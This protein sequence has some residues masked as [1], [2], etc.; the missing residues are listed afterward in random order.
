MNNPFTAI[1]NYFKKKKENAKPTLVKQKNGWDT[2]SWNPKSGEIRCE[3]GMYYVQANSPRNAARKFQRAM[4]K[5]TG[6][7]MKRTTVNK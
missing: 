6:T 4:E 3:T 2:Y 1:K 5:A 7:K